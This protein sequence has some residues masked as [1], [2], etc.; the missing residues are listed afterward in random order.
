MPYRPRRRSQLRSVLRRCGRTGLSALTGTVLAAGLACAPGAAAVPVPAATTAQASAQVCADRPEPARYRDATGSA[1]VSVVSQSADCLR[2]YRIVSTRSDSRQFTE[3]AGMPRVRTGSALIDG[4]YALSI[5]EARLNRASSLTDASYNDGEP[6]PC[7]GGCYVTG[8]N[9]PYVWTRDVAYAADLGLTPIDAARMR[10]TLDFKISERRDGGGGPQIIQDT[11]TG[12]SYPNSTDR[13]TWVLGAMEVLDWLPAKQRT[14]FAARAYAAI[15]GTVEHDRAVVFDTRTKLYRGETSF[16]DWRE[17]TYPAWTADDVTDVTTSTSLS[18]NLVHWVALDS[19]ARLASSAGDSEAAARYR[20]WADDLAW[21]IRQKF[22]R[23]DAG[24]FS[25]VLPNELDTTPVNRYD[26][27]ATSLA[28]LTGVATPQQ[29]KAAVAN[30]P[31]TAY[32]PPVIWPQQQDVPSYHNLAVWPFVT[33]YLQRAAARTGNDAVVT[34]TSSSL[35][36]GAALFGSHMEN[37]DITDGGLDTEMN[38]QRQ[39]WSVAGMQSM[40]QQTMF[41]LDARPDGLHVAPFVPAQ[42]HRQHFGAQRTIG[43]Q[44]LNYRGKALDVTLQLPKVA[45]KGAYTVASM[46]LDGK[47]LAT[48]AVITEDMLTGTPSKL[49]VRLAAPARAADAVVAVDTASRE[50]LYGPKTPSVTSVTRSGSAANLAVDIGGEAAEAVTMSIHRNGVAVARDVPAA[51][52]WRDP[53]ALADRTSPCYAVSL[54]Y[55]SSGN[56]SHNSR[57]ACYWGAKDERVTTIGAAQ[58]EAVGGRFVTG[59]DGVAR[60]EDWGTGADHRLT[61]RFTPTRSGEHLLGADYALDGP[62]N[63]GITGGVKMLSVVD[64][65]SGDV[66]AS[67]VLSLPHTGAGNAVN[68]STLARAA[69]EAGTTYRIELHNDPTAVNMSYFADNALHEA[70]GKGPVNDADVVAMKAMF[71][72]R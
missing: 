2:T 36:R 54:T 40:V 48:D 15:A 1:T 63:T 49:T 33:A 68:T 34:A 64:D 66:V 22:W 3:L 21:T 51:A 24:Q 12:G 17:Q 67:R 16:L 11:G 56:T 18:T 30:Y 13:V 59:P 39:L 6:I 41:G 42:L 45:A 55:R 20:G 31:H 53:K 32:G 8:A 37:I 23:A 29:A 47:P 14:Q 5:H 26:A 9:W 58:L 4:M 27:L 46:S 44:G 19:A 72:G 60:Y 57:P 35:L 61:A 52:T 25:H 71:V 62:I 10:N 28:V 50:A 65:R 69:L 70:A 43:L 38:S 7:P